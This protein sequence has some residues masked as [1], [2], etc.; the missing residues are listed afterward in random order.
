MR[1]LS[2]PITITEYGH[3][4]SVQLFQYVW[5]EDVSIQPS[6]IHLQIDINNIF[7]KLSKQEQYLLNRRFGFIDGHCATFKELGKDLGKSS[8]AVHK[9]FQKLMHTIRRR[10]ESQKSWRQTNV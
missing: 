7:N 9:Q 5:D 10:F 2:G 3:R 6:D 4:N 1:D 8:P